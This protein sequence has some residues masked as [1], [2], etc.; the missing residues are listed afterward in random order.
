MSVKE[1]IS[2]TAEESY[3]ARKKI[4][5]RAM[6]CGFRE[7]QAVF[8]SGAI[9]NFVEGARNGKPLLLIHD[10]TSSW[11]DYIDVLEK[12]AKKY[13]VF[14]VDMPGHGK[15]CRDESLYTA[16]AIGSV[17][18]DFLRSIIRVPC[19]VAGHSVG[20]LIAAW[21]AANAGDMVQ[22]VFL[23][24]PMLFSGEAGRIEKTNVY[25]DSCQTCHVFLEQDETAS[26]DQYYLENCTWVGFFGVL[27][28]KLIEHAQKIKQKDPNAPIEMDMIPD[29]LMHI[30]LYLQQYDPLFG[31]SMYQLRWM[32]G[33]DHAQTLQK[34]QCP[35]YI[36]QTN[37][38][39][40]GDVLMAAMSGEDALRA[41][42]MVPNCKLL[43]VESGH[44]FHYEKPN[45]YVR[46]LNKLCD[47]AF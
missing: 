38:S 7:K 34:I 20:G 10:H 35:C 8:E 24:D 2:V 31:E 13:H 29:S 41:E 16:L 1:I 22:G 4:Q 25:Q 32:E 26:F 9:I 39:I 18:E 27:G 44:D 36:I 19:V 15:S 21:L 33:F 37:W 11:Q 6:K 47:E 23:E 45:E 17:M 42:Q 14:A 5:K 40:K 3:A 28:G 43:E 12:C 46:L 30:F